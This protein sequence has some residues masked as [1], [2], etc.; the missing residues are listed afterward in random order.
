M[1]T[2]PIIRIMLKRLFSYS[3]YISSNFGSSF[4]VIPF[5]AHLKSD[6][7]TYSSDYVRFN[8]YFTYKNINFRYP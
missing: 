4:T 6:F 5:T 8:W 3:I 2:Q 1:L 7:L